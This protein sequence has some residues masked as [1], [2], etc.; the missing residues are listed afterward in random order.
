MWPSAERADSGIFIA[1]QAA[2]LRRAGVDLDVFAFD[3]GGAAPYLKG[4]FDLLR[5]R[6]GTYDVVHAH[7]GLSAWVAM[8]AR[9]RIRAVTFHGTDLV[10]P[11]SRRLSLAALRFIDLP[12]AASA[13]LA[14][15]V[16]DGRARRPLEVLPCGVDLDRA[17][18]IDRDGARRSLGIGAEE[19]VILLPSDPARPEKRADRAR[20][21][22]AATGATLITLG[23]VAPSD[24]PTRISAADLVVIPSER[25]GFGIALLEAL[26]CERPVFSTPVGIAPAALDGMAGVLCSEWDSAVWTRE[27]NSVFDGR[28]VTGGR[29]RAS[30]WSTDRCA[31]DVIAAWTAALDSA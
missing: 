23:G 1:D 19:R 13:E 24:V 8:A 18:A 14:G 15:L 6:D 26:A 11:R 22:A 21:L 28:A 2:A 12:A 10:H 29:E 25:E 3:S 30:R 20:D 9:A 31:A 27:A 4:A 5:R 16:P 7:F 17:T